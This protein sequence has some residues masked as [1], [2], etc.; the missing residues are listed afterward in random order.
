MRLSSAAAYA[1]AA[2]SSAGAPGSSGAGGSSAG[3]SSFGSS[4]C[5]SSAVGSSTTVSSSGAGVGGGDGGGGGGGAS[6]AAISLTPMPASAGSKPRIM[7]D[8]DCRQAKYS[9]SE[10][11]IQPTSSTSTIS[12]GSRS[13]SPTT[14]ASKTRNPASSTNLGPAAVGIV[15]RLIPGGRFRLR[16]QLDPELVELVGRNLARS[17]A[18]RIE[19]GL[20]LRERDRVPQVWLAG[21]HHHQPVDAERDA[22]VGRRAHV[23]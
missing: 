4:T 17:A 22:A 2:E 23:Q 21:K 5:S 14:T 8:S 11:R 3:A 7:A 20:V 6:L 1:I 19:P 13:A 18:H 12:S 10:T 16:L 15:G 9:I